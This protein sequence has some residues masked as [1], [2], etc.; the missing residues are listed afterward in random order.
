[1]PAMARLRPLRS[2]DA[3]LGRYDEA[4]MAN[5]SAAEER[6]RRAPHR[7][8]NTTS[9][10]PGMKTIA[11]A[12]IVLTVLGAARAEELPLK[13][14]QPIGKGY[15]IE[16][17]LAVAKG[18][19]QF[20]QDKAVAK[21]RDWAKGHQAEDQVIILT[22]MLFEKKG[23]GEIRPPMIGAPE[24]LG[25]TT[26]AD[27]PAEPI[28]LYEG[29]PILI[30][31]G[32]MLLGLAERSEDYLNECIKDG[33]WRAVKY[34]EADQPRLEKIIESFIKTAKWKRLLSA[35]EESFLKEQA[36]VTIPGRRQKGK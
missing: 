3:D 11:I 34:T 23:G 2:V 9:A 28:A 5:G 35:D 31:K 20:G 32:Y 26:Y 22:R 7:Y 33:S 15:R 12:I 1:M 13:A 30:T 29:I 17:Y 25:D 16:P 6:K 27:W 8:P 19:Q 21:L 24:L 36:G 4:K 10:G 14:C 18:L